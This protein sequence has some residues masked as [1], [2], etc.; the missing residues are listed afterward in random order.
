MSQVDWENPY[1]S[2]DPMRSYATPRGWT[3]PP[4]VKDHL[5]G[6]IPPSWDFFAAPPPHI[7]AV[8]SAASSLTKE[9]EPMATGTRA[10]VALVSGLIA[11]GI[12]VGV[13]VP[14]E[15]EPIWI[16]IGG[17]IAF[18]L[19]GVI[20]W[21]WN[22]FDHTVHYVGAEGVAMISCSG[23][24]DQIYD[25]QVFRFDQAAELRVDI[26]HH[27]KNGIYQHTNYSYNWTD[28]AGNYVHTISGSHSYEY[29]TPPANDLYNYATS[30][31]TAWSLYLFNQAV[32][33][34]NRQG[35]YQFNLYGG[36]FVRI[37]QGFVE[38]SMGGNQ[39]RVRKED[40]SQ[41]TMESGVLSIRRKD[42]V[43]GWFTSSGVFTFNYSDL[44]NGRLFVVLFEHY[45]AP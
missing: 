43:D 26:T 5:G 12:I 6:Y 27:Y 30:A 28:A 19:V 17:T 40:M 32:D 15:W 33:Q 13:G 22:A 45:A 9:E 31:E 16:G 29:E 10:M 20:A 25:T 39:E 34:I 24:R 37:G 23:D 4:E 2:A 38:L 1:R 21:Y 41:A 36:E 3:P 18:L 11:G 8:T 35:F 42:A 14:F 44:A 7:G